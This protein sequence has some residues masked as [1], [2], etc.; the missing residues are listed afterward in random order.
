[1]SEEAR[2]FHLSGIYV[3][4]QGGGYINKRVHFILSLKQMFDRKWNHTFPIYY[5][6]KNNIFI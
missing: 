5:A 1:M 6:M 3:H 2:D 4:I